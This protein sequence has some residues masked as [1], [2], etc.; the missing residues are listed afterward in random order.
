MP[1]PVEIV[2]VEPLTR[3][4][5]MEKLDLAQVSAKRVEH[6]AGTKLMVR[7]SE[8]DGI[9]M[10]LRPS[11]GAKVIELSP[12]AVE[13]LPSFA[14]YPKDFYKELP[15]E[16]LG[17]VITTLLEGKEEYTLL[18]GRD[19]RVHDFSTKPVQVIAP[20]KVLGV[21]EKILG[22]EDV[23]YPRCAL[24]SRNTVLLEAIGIQETPVVA[25][26]LVRAG[27]QIVFNPLG[28]GVA[29]RVEA[30]ALRMWCTNGATS[31]TAFREF[32]FGRGGE[33]DDI[34]QWFRK[35]IR[36]GVRA[37][38]KVIGE[39]RNLASQNIAPEHRAEILQGLINRAGLKR[40]ETAIHA[41]VLAL[42]E[43]PRTAY[44]LFNVM[45]YA[46]THMVREPEQILKA[47]QATADFAAEPTHSRYCPVC[48]RQ[49][50]N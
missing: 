3:N 1:E 15:P 31:S 9:E 5:V 43:P 14:G 46:T 28:L 13:I 30:Y 10:A 18:L 47:R 8:E 33:G 27:V 35:S 39:Y 4:Q 2:S 37:F 42:P 19:R 44:D 12:E 6:K 45:T 17:K 26:D 29:P 50:N 7:Q 24:M 16:L 22:K 32:E 49:R 48:N 34:W 40:I 21:V 25:G 23:R 41:H 38:D 36:A 11:S 20:H